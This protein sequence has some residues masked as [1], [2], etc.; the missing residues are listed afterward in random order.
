VDLPT[1]DGLAGIASLVTS[2]LLVPTIKALK[3]AVK[4]L[5]DMQIDHDKRLAAL[6]AARPKRRGKRAL[7]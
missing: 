6:E 1:I 3:D 7:L 2:V 4:A 5:K